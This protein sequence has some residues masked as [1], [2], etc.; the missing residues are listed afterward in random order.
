MRRR[1]FIEGIAASAASWPFAVRAQQSE[2]VRRIGV[3]MNRAANDSDGQA[4][5]SAFQQGLKQLGWND[6]HNVRIDTFWGADDID[7]E[8]RCAAELLALAPDV[9]LASG[10]LGMATLQQ[11]TRSVQIVFVAVTDP[12]STG[13]VNS[14]SRPSGN[15]TGFMLF[16]YSFGGKWLELLK[17]IAPNV[18]RVA[19]FRIPTVVSNMPLFAAIQAMAQSLGVE[20]NAFSMHDAEEIEGAITAFARFPNGGLIFTPNASVSVYRDLIITLAARHKLPAIYPYHYM[21]TGGGL[22]SY[23]PDIVD[24]YRRAAGYADRILKGEKSADLPV[25]A[26]TKFELMINLKTAKALGL[27]VPTSLLASADK[28]IE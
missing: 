23:A 17:Q 5:L 22:M 24:M 21:V 20:V 27:T 7:R 2:R 19:V 14:L 18:T 12:V 9:V 13:F 11:A 1:A 15:I 3:L 8:R 28:V 26:P 6:G 25:Q 4:R 16:E 10:S